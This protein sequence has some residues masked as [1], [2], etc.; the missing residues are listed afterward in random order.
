M[1]DPGPLSSPEGEPPLRR[2]A[3][4]QLFNSPRVSATGFNM[5]RCENLKYLQYLAKLY[6]LELS[7]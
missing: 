7:F 3:C 6:K 4:P 2:A 1:E 5:N